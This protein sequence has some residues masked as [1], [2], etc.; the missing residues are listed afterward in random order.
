[1]LVRGTER[2]PQRDAA[3]SLPAVLVDLLEHAMVPLPSKTA[4]VLLSMTTG[5]TVTAEHF[6]R[7][8]AYERER[9]L[10]QRA[11]P[12]LCAALTPSGQ[13]LVPRVWA[14]GTW[15]LAR[16]I[17]TASAVQVWDA[18]AIAIICDVARWHNAYRDRTLRG[19][20]QELS[21]EVLGQAPALEDADAWE[22]LAAAAR[23]RLP[24]PGVAGHSTDQMDAERSLLARE[25]PAA[26]QYFGAPAA[27]RSQ[28]R[29]G[30]E[31]PA[32]GGD[33][34]PLIDLLRKR[35]GGEARAA[36]LASLLAGMALL[37]RRR[38][39]PVEPYE[40]AEIVGM[41]E[42]AVRW[43]LERWRAALPEEASPA[44]LAWQLAQ[45]DGLQELHRLLDVP[46]STGPDARAKERPSG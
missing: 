21:L 30:L 41:D 45:L 27:A 28:R 1:M 17:Q 31:V 8:A 6:G 14:V 29:S 46:V 35:A 38:Q 26:A 10:K 2:P 7:I 3:G 11:V 36:E 18:R 4:R 40:Y 13:A 42:D 43:L 25:V 32:W 9:L 16:R 15:R 5:R 24:G 20:A 37:A 23:A 19:A 44:R 33:A 39:E 12:R 22:E 34:V